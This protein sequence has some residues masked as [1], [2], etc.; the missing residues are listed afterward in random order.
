MS[1]FGRYWK[2]LKKHEK[3]LKHW[4]PHIKQLADKLGDDRK[5]R[6]FTLCARPMIDIFM[7]VREGLLSIDDQS[8]AIESVQFC[9]L[10]PEDFYEIRDLIAREDAGF[11][12]ALE[13]AVL[14][15]DDDFTAE[16]P[17][18][19][20][21]ALRLEDEAVLNDDVKAEQL[22]LK[23]TYFRIKESFPYDFINLDFCDRYYPEPPD[24]LR[25]G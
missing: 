20:S 25:D 14:F 11:Q 1:E 2:D 22:V 17:D 3:R 21:I 16:C 15:Q 24:I 23:R 10:D 19:D 18:L 4:L 13:K 7:L 8:N 5:L 12:A 9:E 6:Y